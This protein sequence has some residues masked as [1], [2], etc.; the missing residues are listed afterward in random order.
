MSMPTTVPLSM[1]VGYWTFNLLA[2]NRS[3][4]LDLVVESTQHEI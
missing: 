4:T 3:R 1:K 2:I